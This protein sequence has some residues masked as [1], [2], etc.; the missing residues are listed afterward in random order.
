MK[1]TFQNV[2]LLPLALEQGASSADATVIID[3]EGNFE[4]VEYGEF[5]CNNADSSTA[6]WNGKYIS[7]AF[8]DGHMH[9]LLFGSS[10]LKL[11]VEKCRSLA[12]IQDLIRREAVARAEAPRV[13][14]HGWIQ[15]S[16]NQLALASDLDGLDSKG[17][18]IYI[19]AKD[20]HSTWCNTAALKEMDVQ[21]M[22]DPEGGTI[23]RDESGDPT[24]LLSEAA[25]IGVVWPYLASVTSF[26]ENLSYV[27]EA[28]RTYNVAGYTGMVELATEQFVWDLLKH[29]K[30]KEPGNFT[31]R[32]ACH[33]L[34]KPCDKVEDCLTQVDQ[35]IELHKQYNLKTSPELRITGIKLV[36]DGVIDACTAAISEPY[37]HKT[38]KGDML[39]QTEHINAV[40]AHADRAGLQC[41][42]HAIGD[43][44]VN[45]AVNAIEANG[46]PG[47]R[48]RIEHLEITRPED[49]VRLGQ[50][51]ITAS[52]QPVHSDPAILRA[53]DKL[54]GK[55]RCRRAFAYSEFEKAS[56]RLAIGTDAPTAPHEPFPNLY[57]AST[58]K[59]A[60]RDHGDE[61][62]LNPINSIPPISRLSAL[63]ASTQ[64]SAYSCFADEITG[65]IESGKSADFIVVEPTTEEIGFLGY[66]VK[67]TWFKGK[68]VWKDE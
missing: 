12:E 30:D 52:I 53:W 44:A 36:L 60:R 34:I 19:S 38:I 6:S 9:V 10:L 18:P 39:W 61:E 66:K 17:R 1:Q 4:V 59:S 25:S 68:L 21:D 64:G 31:A 63:L 33:W 54:L 56:A 14:C 29:L 35:A 22:P 58:R 48:H 43:R 65:S 46:T 42:L 28:I 7:P 16:T 49:A 47:R 13:L 37:N 23:H 2:K 3:D 51:G 55:D 8:F 67:E 20:L 45:T 50:L 5:P 41:A 15:D 57:V 11:D 40:V 26:E 24:G 62:D 27:R 32:M